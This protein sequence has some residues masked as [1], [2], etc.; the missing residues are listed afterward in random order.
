MKGVIGLYKVLMVLSP[1]VW[2]RAGWSV[3]RTFSG[4]ADSQ[5]YQPKQTH[6]QTEAQISVRPTKLVSV[7][8]VFQRKYLDN[9]YWT[10]GIQYEIITG[11]LYCC[12]QKVVKI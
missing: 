1:R 10:E 4:E 9:F 12:L 3:R 8:I 6:S 2:R 7:L 11:Q 5:R